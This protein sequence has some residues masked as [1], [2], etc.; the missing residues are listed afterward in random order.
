MNEASYQM[1]T[2]SFRFVLFYLFC[3]VSILASE[4][5]GFKISGLSIILQK[6]I[7]KENLKSTT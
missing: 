5:L 6:K 3:F 2:M 7:L 4:N 1:N